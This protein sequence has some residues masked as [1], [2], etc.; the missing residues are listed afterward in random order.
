MGSGSGDKQE[1]GVSGY[2]K[3][4]VTPWDILKEGR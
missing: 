4:L 3:W 1:S 2:L